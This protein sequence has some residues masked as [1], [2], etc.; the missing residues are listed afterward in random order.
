MDNRA[1]EKGVLG[2]AV[3][4]YRK[5]KGIIHL[6]IGTYFFYLWQPTYLDSSVSH[7]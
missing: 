4:L 2:Y 1:V 5:H 7:F 6:N 3:R